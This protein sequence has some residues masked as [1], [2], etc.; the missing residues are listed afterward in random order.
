M[1]FS[2]PFIRR[3]L[4]HF[5]HNCAPI[6][7]FAMLQNDPA[8]VIELCEHFGLKSD[9]EM[10]DQD[11]EEIPLLFAALQDALD[12][13]IIAVFLQHTNLPLPHIWYHGKNVLQYAIEL[14]VSPDTLAV[15]LQHGGGQLV[16]ARDPLSRSVTELIAELD[17]D[18]AA[19]NEPLNGYA[20]VVSRQIE[21]WIR[22]S[23]LEAIW[24]AVM[25]FDDFPC[26]FDE[27]AVIQDRIASM[28]E[29]IVNDD[30]QWFEELLQFDVSIES[31]C[32]DFP[33]YISCFFYIWL[34]DWLMDCLLD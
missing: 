9:D 30:E 22:D 13:K 33:Q 7:Y 25:G 24:L 17:A 10:L 18:A 29:C 27:R 15:I 31:A 20:A 21:I 11:G 34:I 3:T 4:K 28:D 19:T 26:G 16:A 32:W 12:V 14:R 5:G 2:R 23:S 8:L 6:L 1:F